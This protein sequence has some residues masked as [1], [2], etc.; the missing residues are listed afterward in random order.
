VTTVDEFV[1]G[2]PNGT[3]SVVGDTR[4]SVLFSC[5]FAEK[6]KAMECLFAGV[7]G[8]DNGLPRSAVETLLDRVGM[9]LEGSSKGGILAS[10]LACTSAAAQICFSFAQEQARSKR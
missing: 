2:E 4:Y 5:Q 3:D 10:S 9:M 1:A 7:E 8:A 6:V